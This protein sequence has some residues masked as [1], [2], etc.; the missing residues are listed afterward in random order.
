MTVHKTLDPLPTLSHELAEWD[1]QLAD[2]YL[3]ERLMLPSGVVDAA[4]ARLPQGVSLFVRITRWA[5][6]VVLAGVAVGAWMMYSVLT[7]RTLEDEWSMVEIWGFLAGAGAIF[8]ALILNLAAP[9]MSRALHAGLW[10][11]RQFSEA[12]TEPRAADVL[13]WRVGALVL[14]VGVLMALR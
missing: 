8:I 3:A 1:R 7:D 10:K 2:A 5:A 13:V 9:R 14:L 11:I 12:T 4:M 6:G